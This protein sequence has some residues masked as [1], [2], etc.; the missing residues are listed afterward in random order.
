MMPGSLPWT[1][2]VHS[3]CG[4]AVLCKPAGAALKPVTNRCSTCTVHEYLK[5]RW[6]RGRCQ[7]EPSF[8]CLYMLAG[9]PNHCGP[10]N[11][12]P[13]LQRH[14]THENYCHPLLPSTT[15]TARR[16]RTTGCTNAVVQFCIFGLQYWELNRPLFII[17][18][19]V[20]GILV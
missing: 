15:D 19:P 17:K 12:L 3:N 14:T 11:S 2:G 13:K 20:S 5:V 9:P 6:Y 1:T 8:P 7:A 4:A 10:P 18:F 16:I